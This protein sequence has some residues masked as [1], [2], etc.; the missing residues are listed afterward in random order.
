MKK[1]S[2]LTSSDCGVAAVAMVAGVPYQVARAIIFPRGP[3][4]YGRFSTTGDDLKR[5]M[6]FLG[7]KFARRFVR[8][9]GDP[10]ALEESAI[11]STIIRTDRHWV[12]WDHDQQRLLD[13]WPGGH[14]R[15]TVLSALYVVPR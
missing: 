8:C 12:V 13:P 9:K 11:L 14:K 7:V 6:K 4:P 15:L 5:A 3:R 2:Q 1:I 10:S